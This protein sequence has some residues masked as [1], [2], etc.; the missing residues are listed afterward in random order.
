MDM[1]PVVIQQT[2]EKP[3]MG[4]PYCPHPKTGQLLPDTSKIYDG[5]IILENHTDKTL[6]IKMCF[7]IPGGYH[8]EILGEEKEVIFSKKMLINSSHKIIE[9]E[10]GLE[11]I[12]LE[13]ST[14]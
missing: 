13:S 7:T 4:R 14:P 12:S 5:W 2:I 8:L 11:S 1:P 9:T 10:N 6:E 3:L